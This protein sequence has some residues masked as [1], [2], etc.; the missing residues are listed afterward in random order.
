[1]S[2]LLF[3]SASSVVATKQEVEERGFAILPAIFDSSEIEELIG[4]IAK[5]KSA[6]GV[7]TRGGV[8]A[9]R[10]LLQLSPALLQ[11]A[12]SE[13]LLAIVQSHIGAG[14]FAVKGTLFDK[15][16]GANWL[17]PWHQDLTISVA[18]R[19]PVPGY[20][21]WTVKAGA[22]HVQPPTSVL[23]GMLSIRIHLDD[24]GEENGPLRVLPG[25]HRSGRLGPEKVSEL[26]REVREHRCLVKTGGLLLMKPLLLHAS[27]AAITPEHR[28]VVHIDYASSQLDGGLRWRLGPED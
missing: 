18:S 11:L 14:A 3:P 17:V 21:P 15:T 22:C 2:S 16:G 26:V 19:L 10:N 4:L 1:M 20:G 7:R 27:S 28:R 25:T 13:N 24:C 9:V 8:Y 5:L 6:D 12:R 23:N